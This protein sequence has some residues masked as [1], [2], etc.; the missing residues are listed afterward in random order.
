MTETTERELLDAA[1]E[2]GELS[3]RKGHGRALAARLRTAQAARARR[4]IAAYREA[5]RRVAADKG[6]DE[7]DEIL[8]NEFYSIEKQLRIAS[9]ALGEL[10]PGALPVFSS[11]EWV[12]RARI[13][14]LA[15]VFIEHEPAAEPGA[16]NAFFTEYQQKNALTTREL[17]LLGEMLRLALLRETEKLLRENAGKRSGTERALALRRLLEGFVRLSDA[18]FSETMRKLNPV[19]RLLMRDAAYQ[20]MAEES[21]GGYLSAVE[22]IARRTGVSELVAA[23][24][25]LELAKSA[26]GRAGHVGYFLIDEGRGELLHRLRPDRFKNEKSAVRGKERLAVFLSSKLLLAAL[27]AVA[28]GLADGSVWTGILSF[29]PLYGAAGAL[30]MRLAARFTKPRVLPRLELSHGVGPENRTLVCVPVLITGEKALDE[31]VLTLER[32]YLAD[33][34]DNIELCVLGDFP[35]SKTERKDGEEEL[36][37]RAENAIAALNRR[38]GAAV[39]HFLH[40]NR[41]FSAPDGLFMGRERKRGAV[42]ALLSYL[43]EGDGAEFALNAPRLPRNFK[44]L[45]VLDA[46]T[47][48][49]PGA[50][51]RLIGAA[52]HPLNAPFYA[53]SSDMKPA[54]GYNIIVPRMASTSR[55]CAA[56]R[57]AALISGESGLS[58]YSLPVSEFNFDTFAEANFGG[59]G[60]I[61][62]EGFIR[63]TDG[64]IPENTVLSHDLLEGCLSRAGL[65]SSTVLYDGEPSS[66]AAWWKRRHRWLRGDMQ[67]LPFLLGK[68]AV[69]LDAVSKYKLLSNIIGGFSNIAAFIALAAGIAAGLPA[70]IAFASAAFF[71][72]PLLHAF[73]M[74]LHLPRRVALRPLVLLVRRRLLELA[75]LPYA[76]WRDADAIG[77]ALVRMG[78]THRN[79]LQ[80]QT[81]ADSAASGKK[82]WPGLLVCPAVG[83]LLIL[84]CILRSIRAG[85]IGFADAAG[86]ALGSLFALAPLIV[87]RLEG[88]KREYVFKESERGFLVEAARRTWRFFEENC[89]ERTHFLPP[90][91]YQQEPGN[92]PA[93]LTSPT[94][95]GMGLMAAVAAYDFGFIDAAVLITRLQKTVASIE[96]LEKWHGN[97]FNWY[98]I[99]NLS[100]LLPRFVSSVDCGNLLCALMTAAEAVRGLPESAPESALS[101]EAEAL[102]TRLCRLCDEMEL[103]ALYDLARRLFHIGCEF[104]EGRLTRSHYDLWASEAR[105]TSFSAIA[106]GKIGA[107]HWSSL[108]RLVCDTQ[109]GRSLKSW[110]G[111]AFEYLMPLLFFETVNGSMQL[112]ACR[113]AVLEQVLDSGG[114]RPW[115]VSESGYFAF[116]EEMRYQYRA[117]GT[118][119]LALARERE[120]ETVV[121]PYASALALAVEPE[122]AAENLRRLE[123]L[124]AFGEYGFFEALDYTPSRAGEKPFAPVRSFMAH[125][126]GMIL[127]ALDNALNDGAIVKRFMRLPRVRANEQLL[128]E[129]LPVDPIR[130]SKFKGA[131]S[132]PPFGKNKAAPMLI[133]AEKGESAAG[134]LSN[135]HYSVAMDAEGRSMS[136]LGTRLLTRFRSEAGADSGIEFIVNTGKITRRVGGNLTVEP[137]KLTRADRIGALKLR[138]ETLVAAG[139]DGEMRTLELINCGKTPLRCAVGIFAEVCLA[140]EREDEAHPAFTRLRV[141]AETDGESTLLFRQRGKP[142]DGGCVGYFNIAAP[143]QAALSTD[144]LK[145][146]GRGKDCVRAVEKLAAER[147]DGKRRSI[148]PPSKIP[149]EPY[150]SAYTEL[151]LGAGELAAVRLICGLAEDAGKARAALSAIRSGVSGAQTLARALSDGRL[152]ALGVREKEFELASRIASCLL[153]R[154]AAKENPCTIEALLRCRGR[155]GEPLC[156]KP[157]LWRF[158]ISGDSPLLIVSVSRTEQLSRVGSVLRAS[159]YIRSCAL[160]HDTVLIGEYPNEYGEPLRAALEKLVQGRAH[161]RLLHGFDLSADERLFLKCCA[162]AVIEADDPLRA[163]KALPKAE[164]KRKETGENGA[165]HDVLGTYPPENA[166]Q[167]LELFNGYGGLDPAS[168]EYRIILQAGMKTPLPWS[169]VIAGESAGT[170]MTESGGCTFAANARLDRIT[171]WTNDALSLRFPERLELIDENGRAIPI[172]PLG[173]G[174]EAAHGFGYTRFRLNTEGLEVALTVTADERLPVKYYCVEVKNTGIFD[175]SPSLCFSVEFALGESYRP[176]CTLSE[177]HGFGCTAYNALSERGGVG[178]IALRS[179]ARLLSAETGRACSIRAGLSIPAGEKA[180]AVLLL[181]CVK[182]GIGV[183][184]GLIERAD[185]DAALE[186]KRVFRREKLNRLKL[187]TGDARFD[188]LVNERLLAQLYSA[189]L[190]GKTGFYQSGGATGFRDQLQDVSALLATDPARAKAQLLACAAKQ[191]PEGDVLHW[192]HDDGRGVRTRI[193]DDRLFLPL[194]ACEYAETTGD[195]GIFDLESPFLESIPLGG[196]SRTLYM[197]FSENGAGSLFE[198][199]CRAV[200]LSLNSLGEHGLPLMGGGDWNDGMDRVGDGGGESTVVGFLAVMAAEK[201]A[202]IADKRGETARAAAFTEKAKHLRQALEDAAW[203]GRGYCRAFFADGTPLGVTDC[204]SACFAVFAGAEHSREAFG[205]AMEEL[206]DGENNLVKLLWPP[207]DAEKE[208]QP[209]GYIEGY[210]AGV[211]ENGGQYTHAAAWCVIAACRLGLAGM[212]EKLFRMLNPFEHGD[213]NGIE[214]Y[215]TEPYAVCG[216]VYSVGSRAG[217]GGWSLYTG[218]AGW[219]YRAATEHILGI[220]KRGERL[221]ILPCTTL[222]EFRFEYRFGAEGRTLYRIHAVRDGGTADFNGADGTPLH[223]DGRTHELTAA[224]G[225][226]PR[227]R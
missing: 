84:Y 162:L 75:A 129:S 113:S 40:R 224:Y 36:L 115:G 49:P 131:P 105:L 54:A 4:L 97:P 186:A 8:V 132:R 201:L 50:L 146:P 27:L 121:A 101:Q 35:D 7:T 45:V 152:R 37:Q 211:R 190:L 168:G 208:R 214:R 140:D 147:A 43:R 3:I 124:G 149:V 125:H 52:A 25:A 220:R 1:R 205:A 143:E 153:S 160:L 77:R 200:E 48:L 196:E 195:S 17:L 130:I 199:C 20:E 134:V 191:F 120:R 112:E 203:D 123:N 2:L 216:D 55:S 198:H 9:D 126:Q 221:F 88:K 24:N 136:R 192:W 110:S 44:Y 63:A 139:Q 117:F 111:T 116:D 18:D 87:R 109:G 150:F 213:A 157:A 94:N 144:G 73:S 185:P 202:G 81:A 118:P 79:M 114:K 141:E 207:F 62:I 194:V 14:S 119:S 59:K 28:A 225:E 70:L 178:F 135:G 31:A 179:G 19:D 193:S 46:D 159:E 100:L 197:R 57:F 69:K 38:S 51:R 66:F 181:G 47:V 171:P 11:G 209:V 90:D 215:K 13:H 98:N 5:C 96:K 106:S 30:L 82:G 137:H 218:A 22:R 187:R 182:N 53:G 127:L 91:N 167:G 170:L 174:Y 16:L 103:E 32:H 108:S 177:A 10:R 64:A 206:V 58:A 23:R 56:S 219:L 71:A 212:A 34:L 227:N 180:R 133:T 83:A 172:P 68:T 74:L 99:E 107:E 72:D 85:G 104:D 138:L 176:E 60:I 33:P 95:I 151:T 169:N 175:R 15:A 67:L 184:E 128:F 166:A 161:C 173:G 93:K 41:Q 92:G 21:R 188:A 122:L 164:K 65:S 29:L 78:F 223:D 226:N 183:I 163:F 222:P 6:A 210:L 42:E 142:D 217:R 189:R 76:A 102:Y 156:G 12:G 145:L 80:W 155:N 86:F 61:N 165:R 39:F 148:E 154:T 26:G 158:G 89:T 204:V